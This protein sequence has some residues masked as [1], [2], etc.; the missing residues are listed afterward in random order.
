MKS[1]KMLWAEAKGMPVEAVNC[2]RDDREPEVWRPAG[3]PAKVADD[4]REFAAEFPLDAETTA[5]LTMKGMQLGVAISKTTMMKRNCGCRR[6][7]PSL[8]R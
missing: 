1:T 2:R 8:D 7:A 5:V 4:C 3:M 6:P